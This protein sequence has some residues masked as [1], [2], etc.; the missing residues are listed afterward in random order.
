MSPKSFLLL[1]FLLTFASE[2]WSAI[3]YI[4]IEGAIQNAQDSR[5]ANGGEVIIIARF[6]DV[7]TFGPEEFV[8]GVRQGCGSN[9]CPHNWGGTGFYYLILPHHT[10]YAH[11]GGGLGFPGIVFVDRKPAQLEFD[12]VEGERGSR[13]TVETRSCVDGVC[14]VEFSSVQGR[15]EVRF[16]LENLREQHIVD[17]SSSSSPCPPTLG[18]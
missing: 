11:N 6:D 4:E 14:I 12:F 8:D 1:T 15:F 13:Y 3:Q 9:T 18:P 16:E 7:F 10:L 17:P 5:V 2:G